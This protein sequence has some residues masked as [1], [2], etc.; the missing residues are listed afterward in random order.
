MKKSTFLKAALTV[1]AALTFGSAYAQSIEAI[2]TDYTA[3]ET[4][5]MYQTVGYAFRLYA[6]P[7]PVYN[8]TNSTWTFTTTLPLLYGTSGIAMAQNWV[9]ITNAATIGNYTVDVVEGNTLI[10]CTDATPVTTTIHIVAAPTATITT[11]DATAYCGDQAAQTISVA[12]T[13]NVPDAFAAYAFS[14][15][16]TVE[17]IDVNGDVIG[18]PTTNA[19]FVNHTVASM[20]ALT[21]TP[22]F[23]TTFSSSALTVKNA[24]RTRYTYTLKKASDASAATDG[25]ISAISAKSN[26]T[27]TQ[28]A[29][30]FTDSEVV[31]LVNPTPVTGPIYH[32]PNDFAL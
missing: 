26:I 22:N 29:F 15:T 19:T 30:A 4:E 24:H 21:G 3:T 1:I 25:I 2:P 28:V 17:E 5:E 20:L 14:V 32:L 8:G 31:F 11:T 13:E 12:I 27:G 23:T 9:E 18:T 6:Q 16:E 7:D 10:G